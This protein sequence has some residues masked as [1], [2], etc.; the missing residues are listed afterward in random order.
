MACATSASRTSLIGRRADRGLNT[1]SHMPLVFAIA[2]RSPQ[3]AKFV[4]WKRECPFHRTPCD[5]SFDST[6]SYDW[7]IQQAHGN[8]LLCI[9]SS[10]HHSISIGRYSQKHYHRPRLPSSITRAP[11]SRQPFLQQ[12]RS[13]DDVQWDLARD[14][15]Y[16]VSLLKSADICKFFLTLT[17]LRAES[18]ATKICGMY[19]V[20][21]VQW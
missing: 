17:T 11:S 7:L 5:H 15:K 9:N 10:G 3:Q 6:C 20:C 21:S 12:D 1:R 13:S 16:C 4:L 18:P 8:R 19:M 2:L 14:I